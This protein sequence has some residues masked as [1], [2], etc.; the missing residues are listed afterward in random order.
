M[1]AD[2]DQSSAR[3]QTVKELSRQIENPSAQA[4]GLSLSMIAGQLRGDHEATLQYANKLVELCDRFNVHWLPAGLVFQG[5]AQTQ[6]DARPEHLETAL[7]GFGFWRDASVNLLAPYLL[8]LVAE[9]QS[10]L[11]YCDEAIESIGESI[12]MAQENREAWTEGELHRIH[13]D[14]LARCD[15]A[16]AE[17]ESCYE[18]GLNVA[19]EQQARSLMLRCGLRLAEIWEQRGDSAQIKDLL[20]PIVD[21]FDP[22][23]DS[24]ELEQARARISEA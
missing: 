14:I 11:G 22:N 3:L 17:I 6:R 10:T 23:A 4:F 21:Q 24:P 8:T 16:A 12:A 20:A 15:G 9:I 18:R 2:I 13:G 1:L 7:S 5:W 19:R